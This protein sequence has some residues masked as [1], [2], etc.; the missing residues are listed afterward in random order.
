MSITGK[1]AST[2]SKFESESGMKIRNK[3]L[4][5]LDEALFIDEEI[6]GHFGH[7]MRFMTGNYDICISFSS[8][9]IIVF[10]GDY[11]HKIKSGAWYK[12]FVED[13]LE[14]SLNLPATSYYVGLQNLSCVTC[15]G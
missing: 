2:L 3:D 12:S 10:C 1:G 5:L 15:P 7:R 8:V 13:A 14:C 6:V 4:L 11:M 9:Y